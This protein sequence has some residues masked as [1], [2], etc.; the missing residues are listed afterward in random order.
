MHIWHQGKWIVSYEN[1]LNDGA[2]ASNE[3]F[4]L[5]DQRPFVDAIIT[6]EQVC[7]STHPDDLIWDMWPGSVGYCDCLEMDGHRHV[8]LNMMCKGGGSLDPKDD[9]KHTSQDRFDCRGGI[10]LPPIVQ[11]KFDGVR[12]CGARSS[13]SFREMQRPVRKSDGTFACPESYQACNPD[14][15][16]KPNG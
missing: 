10:G 15:L 7:P 5:W 1:I 13:Y 8:D 16:T 4:N 14:F 3:L 12:Y 11:N 9:S 2:G 6:P